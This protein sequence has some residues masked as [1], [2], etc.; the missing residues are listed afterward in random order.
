MESHA[1]SA[2]KRTNETSRAP[3]VHT[4]STAHPTSL[5]LVQEVLKARVVG[6]NHKVTVAG[7]TPKEAFEPLNITC[8]LFV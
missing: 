5:H 8:S 4:P 1:A 6:G 7:S 3:L 2:A